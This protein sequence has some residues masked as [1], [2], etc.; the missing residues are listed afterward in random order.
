VLDRYCI[1]HP[2]LQSATKPCGQG[3]ILCEITCSNGIA[4]QSSAA[5][6]APASQSVRGGG[7]AKQQI[8]LHQ[9][10]QSLIRGPE[11]G[12][13]SYGIRREAIFA[14]RTCGPHPQA[15]GLKRRTGCAEESS[16]RPPV[17]ITGRPPS[18]CRD[19]SHPRRTFH[20][21]NVPHH[22]DFPSPSSKCCPV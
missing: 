16:V 22:R 7:K 10:F 8:N 14:Q 12:S 21:A 6:R 4:R 2:I 17:H 19:G 1:D 13:P 9:D 11:A 18:V 3:G 20:W 5:D 15:A